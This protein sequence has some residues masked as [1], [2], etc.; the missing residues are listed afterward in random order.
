MNPHA[1]LASP[2][3]AI[4]FSIRELTI[5]QYEYEWQLA[6]ALSLCDYAKFLES[7]S[8][9]FQISV[10]ETLNV[11]MRSHDRIQEYAEE[12]EVQRRTCLT[13]PEESVALTYLNRLCLDVDIKRLK[14][15]SKYLESMYIVGD[16]YET[17]R[18]A[19][20]EKLC[21]LLEEWTSQ[22]TL[23]AAQLMTAGVFAE[24]SRLLDLAGRHMRQIFLERRRI[25]TFTT[26]WKPWLTDTSIR[27][28]NISAIAHTGI[29]GRIISSYYINAQYEAI[30]NAYEQM[31]RKDN[32]SSVEFLFGAMLDLS[33]ELLRMERSLNERML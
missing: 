30:R 13:G 26:I 28:D 23:E 17:V 15:Q 9:R 7:I 5:L 10:T 31:R 3:S 21:E 4:I 1:L 19:K 12:L 20:V 6:K 14:E 29:K 18:K 11:I 22:T 2:P 33:R 32:E 27:L 24:D 8:G 16:S 25:E